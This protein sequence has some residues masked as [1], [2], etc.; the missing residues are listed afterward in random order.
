MGF[1]GIA[2]TVGVALGFSLTITPPVSGQS[3]AP[4]SPE[5]SADLFY[6]SFQTGQWADLADVLHPDA[7]ALFQ[8]RLL[9]VVRTDESGQVAREVFGVEPSALEAM[10]TDDLFESLL[11]GILGY[12]PGM[13]QAMTG[14]R[15]RILGHVVEAEY[16][17]EAIQGE[18]ARDGPTAHVVL[19]TREPLSGSSPSRVGILSLA[20]DG[21]NWKV[22]GSEELDVIATALVAVPRPG[23]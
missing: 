15:V 7:L 13:I 21:T 11:R 23:T 5:Y 14:K 6:Q 9:S 4:S 12:A 22:I 16:G 1:T 17:P 18:A 20:Q 10:A 3:F 19:R 8:R 2:K